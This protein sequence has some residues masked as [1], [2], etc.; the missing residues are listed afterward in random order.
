MHIFHCMYAN[1][2]ISTSGLKSDV[3]KTSL[4]LISCKTREFRRFANIRGRYRLIY[5]CMDFQDL[6]A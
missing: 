2:Y 3:A 6:L 4:I 1:S 5:V